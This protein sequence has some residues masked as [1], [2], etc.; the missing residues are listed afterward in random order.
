MYLACCCRRGHEQHLESIEVLSLSLQTS[1]YLLSS[2]MK[3]CIQALLPLGALVSIATAHVHLTYPPPRGPFVA[4][5]EP[6]FCGSCPS[7]L[8]SNVYLSSLSQT[9]TRTPVRTGHH[10]HSTVVSSRLRAAIPSGLVSAPLLLRWL[11][12]TNALA[13]QSVSSSLLLTTR[14]T[15]PISLRRCSS[16]K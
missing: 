7:R 4:N 13:I 1:Y 16:S 12:L 9:A 14:R 5:Q 3:F 11:M 15:L 2:A 8:L 6:A 10:S